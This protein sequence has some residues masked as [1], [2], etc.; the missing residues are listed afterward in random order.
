MIGLDLMAAEAGASPGAGAH[1]DVK[2]GSGGE[3]DQGP[4]AS[5]FT[6]EKATVTVAPAAKAKTTAI[7]RPTAPESGDAPSS[8]PSSTAP[9]DR[10]WLIVGGLAAA[11]IGALIFFF[12]GGKR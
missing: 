1:P 10:K 5:E 2:W 11:V 12:T 8:A 4:P 6:S 9:T 7:A 3:G